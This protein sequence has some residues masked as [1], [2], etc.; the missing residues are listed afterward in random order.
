M[1]GLLDT[2][3]VID[4]LRDHLPAISWLQAQQEPLGLSPVVWLEIIEGAASKPDQKRAVQLLERFE[5]VE[6]APMDFDWAIR[7]ALALRLSH[8]IDMMDCL[9]A[10]SAQRLQLPLFTRNLKHFQPLIG[11]LALKP[12]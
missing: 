6:V 7:G 1:I 9:I 4:I 8:N 10:A 5:R 12:Y 11:S 3:I 2:A